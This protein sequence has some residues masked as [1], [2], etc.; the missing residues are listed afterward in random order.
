MDA[1]KIGSGTAEMSQSKAAVEPDFISWHLTSRVPQGASAIASQTPRRRSH[2]GR[3]KYNPYLR[4]V[5]ANHSFQRLEQLSQ[6]LAT[7]VSG[8]VYP[9]RLRPTV[10]KQIVLPSSLNP[11]ITLT[12]KRQLTKKCPSKKP[13]SLACSDE[14]KKNNPKSAGKRADVCVSLCAAEDQAEMD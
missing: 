12:S 5:H 14:K 4:I 7:P 6:A 2:C 1:T 8:A 9:K 13:H 11:A 10:R 3:F